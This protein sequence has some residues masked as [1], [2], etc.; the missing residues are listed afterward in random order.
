MVNPRED[1]RMNQRDAVLPV[2]QRYLAAMRRGEWETGYG[3]FADDIV[4][5]VP[6]RSAFAG[7]HRGRDAAVRYIESALA[8]CDD[9][10]LELVDMLASDD[11]V[12]L[13]LRE[14]FTRDER[15]IEIRRANVYRI[16]EGRVAEIQIFEADQYEADALLTGAGVSQSPTEQA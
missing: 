8:A 5:H 3:L 11:R 12:A 9:V 16:R 2:M 1:T 13:I 4:L 14:R 7:T 6:G 15:V 10:E